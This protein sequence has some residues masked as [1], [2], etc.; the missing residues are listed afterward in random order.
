MARQPVP[1]SQQQH[2]MIL[3][4]EPL[5]VQ[6][7]LQLFADGCPEKFRP[8]ICPHCLTQV[9]LHRHGKYNRH[10]YTPDGQ[11]RLP[12]YRFICPNPNCRKTTAL[13]PSFLKEHHQISL[14]LQEKVIRQQAEGKTLVQLSEELEVPG[15]PFSEKTIWRWIRTWNKDLVNYVSVVWKFILEFIPHL[16]LP[17]GTNKP[18]QEW[19][20]LFYAWDQLKAKF[21]RIAVGSMLSWL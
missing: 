7:Y 15:G 5:T 16:Q 1:S 12:I 6:T 3:I 8:R 13:L 14:D 20:W 2:I 21:P 9:L 11:S 18:R 4:E 19:G 17:V 10:A